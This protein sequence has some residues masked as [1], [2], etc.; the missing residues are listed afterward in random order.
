M[1][2]FTQQFYNPSASTTPGSSVE[3]DM[4]DDASLEDYFDNYV[5]LS[6]LPTP[7]PSAYV[8]SA[9]DI[10][11]INSKPDSHLLGKTIIIN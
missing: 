11:Q 8:H 4:D 3:I 5:P 7:P 1:D 2:Y 9:P 6:N 10:L